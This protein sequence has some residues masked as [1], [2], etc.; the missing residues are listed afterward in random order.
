[1]LNKCIFH[2]Q[3]S[4]SQ[5]REIYLKYKITIRTLICFRLDGKSEWCFNMTTIC[6]LHTYWNGIGNVL[7]RHFLTNYS[8]CGINV[9]RYILMKRLDR[10]FSRTDHKLDL[11][12]MLQTY[13]HTQLL[14]LRGEVSNTP[15]FPII[16]ISWGE[17]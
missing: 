12:S 7:P 11:G 17:R 1:M 16:R 3:F 6:C 5:S 4:F 13:T 15:L 2:L 9:S 10:Q 14:N 8:G